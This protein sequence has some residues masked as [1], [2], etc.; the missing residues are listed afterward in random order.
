MSLY[1]VG[2]PRRVRGRVGSRLLC[3]SAAA[4]L[5]DPARRS[6]P[7]ARLRRVEGDDPELLELNTTCTVVY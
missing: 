1:E 7:P 6:A 5:V 2:M 4:M 3:R